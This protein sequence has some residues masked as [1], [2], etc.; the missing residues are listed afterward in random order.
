[1]H[2]FVPWNLKITVYYGFV[3]DTNLLKIR[4]IYSFGMATWNSKCLDIV[5]CFGSVSKN[6]DITVDSFWHV[7][8]T[9]SILTTLFFQQAATIPE[10]IPFSHWQCLRLHLTCSCDVVLENNIKNISQ[11]ELLIGL[12]PEYRK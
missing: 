7:E 3:Y 4:D 5:M 2:C 10:L 9:E 1:M 11:Q 8:S 12:F 6:P